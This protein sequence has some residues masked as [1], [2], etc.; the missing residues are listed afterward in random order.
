M[1][2]IEKNLQIQKGKAYQVG[3]SVPTSRAQAVADALDYLMK[4][5]YRKSRSAIV[6]DAIIAYAIQLGFSPQDN[7]EVILDGT[8][9]NEAK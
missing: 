8:E 7:S 2:T 5:E 3:I 9:V 1:N 6:C 4:H